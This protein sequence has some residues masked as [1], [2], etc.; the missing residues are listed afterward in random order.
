M[1]SHHPAVFNGST[2]HPHCCASPSYFK[3]GRQQLRPTT[4][5]GERLNARGNRVTFHMTGRLS[6]TVWTMQSVQGL[7]DTV[8]GPKLFCR[9]S[10]SKLRRR[11]ECEC[12]NEGGNVVGN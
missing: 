3:M 7:C 10:V 11:L 4:A 9:C 5:D 8:L 1:P 12:M 2:R 6:V